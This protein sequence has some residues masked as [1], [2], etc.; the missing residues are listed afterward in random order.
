MISSS[1]VK[2]RETRRVTA[3][4]R[5]REPA[6]IGDERSSEPR[7]E[8][9][10]GEPALPGAKGGVARGGT[11]VTRYTSRGRHQGQTEEL[12]PPTGRQTGFEGL[13]L[14]R[15]EGTKIGDVWDRYDDLRV[16]QQLGLVPE[17]EQP[18]QD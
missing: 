10:A 11:T 12:G 3:S 5:R 9:S 7:R 17:D 6:A 18:G 8:V 15:F 13:T 4:V 1:P 14:Y 16:L 2:T